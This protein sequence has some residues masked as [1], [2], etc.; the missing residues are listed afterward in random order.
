MTRIAPV[1]IVSKTNKQYVPEFHLVLKKTRRCGTKSACEHWTILY[2][3]SLLQVFD[4]PLE[5]SQ[6]N[7]TAFGACQ[8]RILNGANSPMLA[9]ANWLMDNGDSGPGAQWMAPDLH[10]KKCK[11]HVIV[12]CH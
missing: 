1:R 3:L 6:N 5:I 9:H 4:L 2:V 8:I 7:L 12:C 11:N 10:D